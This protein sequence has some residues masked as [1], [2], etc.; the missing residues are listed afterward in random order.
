MR[1]RHGWCA[2]GDAAAAF[3][4]LSSHGM[5]TALWSGR[6]AALGID[7]MLKG[8]AESLRVYAETM[9]A[10]VARYRVECQAV[11]AQEWRYADRPFWR[12]RLP[13]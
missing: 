8:E 3:D 12:R 2:A 9:T 13:T 4:P 11:Y 1:D 10:G 6:Q 7:A 5:T